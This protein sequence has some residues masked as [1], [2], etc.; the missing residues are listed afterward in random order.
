MRNETNNLNTTEGS[1]T[2]TTTQTL[3]TVAA[4]R[5]MTLEDLQDALV[6]A[7]ATRDAAWMIQNGT[8]IEDTRLAGLEEKSRVL[9]DE[10]RRRLN[11]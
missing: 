10:L 2:M 8:G 9:S 11:G 1:K 5:T 4:T 6:S 3:K 7:D